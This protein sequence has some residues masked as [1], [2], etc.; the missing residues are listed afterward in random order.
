MALHSALTDPELH[1]CKG[2]AAA[3]ANTVLVANGTGTASFTTVPKAA[4]STDVKGV[5]IYYTMSQLPDMSTAGFVLVPVLATATLN[6]VTF[7]L[8]NAI[9]VANS[10]CTMVNSTGPATVGSVNVPFTGSAEGTTVTFTASVNNT[11]VPGAYLKISTD[12]NSTTT[13]ITDIISK[14]TLA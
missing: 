11:F 1:E 10:T 12:G 2:A 7:I 6:T 4:L 3:S 13:A 8:H 5:G 14:W 9:T